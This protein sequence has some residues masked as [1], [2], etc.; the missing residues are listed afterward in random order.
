M[1]KPEQI[2]DEAATE[3]MKAIYAANENLS[4]PAL[5]A[6]I[7]NA[8]NAWPGMDVRDYYSSLSSTPSYAEIILPLPETRE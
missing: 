2:P 8:I 3:G 1:I 5:N 6:A 7:A 4:Y